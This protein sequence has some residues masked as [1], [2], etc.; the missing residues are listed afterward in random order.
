MVIFKSKKSK[1][2]LKLELHVKA[3]GCQLVLMDHK[4]PI[5]LTV[6]LF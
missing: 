2:H 5:V 4:S 3:C 1:Y 6:E